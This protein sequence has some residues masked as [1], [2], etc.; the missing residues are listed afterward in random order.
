MSDIIHGKFTISSDLEGSFYDVAFEP[1]SE[2]IWAACP[3][4]FGKRFDR[5][6]DAETLVGAHREPKFRDARLNGRACFS[7]SITRSQYAQYATF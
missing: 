1:E 2:Q 7:G 4:G 6:E 3:R 5:V